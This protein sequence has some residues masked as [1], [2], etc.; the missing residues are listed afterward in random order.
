MLML[1]GVLRGYTSLEPV[2]GIASIVVVGSIVL[3]AVNIL[4]NLKG[5][6]EA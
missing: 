3:F 5:Q 4:K 6:D 1:A 2:L